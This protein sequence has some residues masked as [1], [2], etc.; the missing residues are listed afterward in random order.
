MQKAAYFPESLSLIFDLTL[1]KV[2]FML[3]LDPE[4]DQ[5]PDRNALRFR[6]RQGKKVTVPADCGSSYTSTTLLVTEIYR[7]I[8]FVFLKNDFKLSTLR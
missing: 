8:Y 6:F 2:H 5:E 3:D 1:F 4:P 7:Y